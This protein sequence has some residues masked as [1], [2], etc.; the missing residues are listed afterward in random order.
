MEKQIQKLLEQLGVD[1]EVFNED[2]TKQLGLLIE[3]KVGEHKKELEEQL[4]ETNRE[5]IGEFKDGLIDQLDSYLEYFVEKYIEDNQ[6]E[7]QSAVEVDTARR[8]LEKFDGMVNEF[9][10]NLSEDNIS[11]EQELDELKEDYNKSVNSNMK[12]E[13]ENKELKRQSMVA[14]YAN[15]HIDVDS[16]KASFTRL[17]E[18]FE[19]IDEDSF[20]D[21][22]DYL[23]ENIHITKSSS[24]N[25]D[26]TLT[27]KEQLDNQASK[28]TESTTTGDNSMKQYLTVLERTS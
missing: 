28:L 21:K 2:F 3:A 22:L 6:E 25:D 4:E 14:E 1:K 8:V 27:D 7:I 12:L 24:D 20:K 13:R 23:K 5:E 10:M 11:N 16:E 17:A 15:D 18:N 26:N 9:N 19:Y